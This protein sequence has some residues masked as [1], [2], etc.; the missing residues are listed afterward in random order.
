[1]I[2]ANILALNEQEHLPG[3]LELIRPHVGEIVVWVDDRTTDASEEIAREYAD[4]V[5]VGALNKD[6][7]QA[8]NWCLDHSR[9]EWVLTLDPDERPMPELLRWLPTVQAVDAVQTLHEN[10]ID[11]KPVEG[12]FLEW[13]CRFFR[14]QYR[15]FRPL[16]EMVALGEA[17]VMCA[18]THLRI[19]HYKSQE[20]QEMQNRRYEEWTR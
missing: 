9:G 20:R 4:V 5:H 6:F 11:G 13:H 2:S 17:R 16:H 19:L 18:P 1:V 15:W 8:R 3:L 12:H 7:A 14:K 10:R